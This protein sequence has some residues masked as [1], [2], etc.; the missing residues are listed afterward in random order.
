VFIWLTFQHF[1]P[2]LREVKAGSLRRNLEAGT[3]AE[4]MEYDGLYMPRECLVGVGVPLWAWA[5]PP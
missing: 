5:L 4:F 1:S 2:S 3:E